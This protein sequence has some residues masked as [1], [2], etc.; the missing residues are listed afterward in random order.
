MA[1][2]MKLSETSTV[3]YWTYHDD[4][5]PTIVMIHGFTGSHEG[6]Q[7][8]IPSL[9]DYHCIVPDLPGFGE[10]T[11]GPEENWSIDTIARL[12]N[13]FVKR[14]NLSNPPYLLGHSM[15]GLVASSMLA[16]AKTGLYAK[17]AI[18]LS[19]VPTAI[20]RNDRRRIGAVLGALQ[21]KLGH[22]IPGLGPRLV[23]SKVI[24]AAI[25]RSLIK[26]NDK[27][28]RSAIYGHHFKNLDYISSIK[29]Y[30]T[31]HHD[32][33]QRG[34]IDFAKQLH[35]YKILLV[36]GDNDSVTPITEQRKLAQAISPEEFRVLSGAGHLIHY[37]AP[38]E[39]SQAICSFLG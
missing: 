11:I 23:G 22:T 24:S 37:E 6:F 33:N 5:S 17:K 29:F 8:I 1:H 30:S 39:I 38:G 21:Y 3:N 10:S 34:A 13:E 19:P 15:G 25:T 2:T 12:A 9:K 27:Q 4:K 32:I 35:D 7:Y 36:C 20:R 16:Q 31:L 26:T 18:L 28:L 14:L